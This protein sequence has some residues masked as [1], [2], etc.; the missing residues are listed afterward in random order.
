MHPRKCM[1]CEI[2]LNGDIVF[3][4]KLKGLYLDKYSGINEETRNEIPKN[5][6]RS[7]R[8]KYLGDIRREVNIKRYMM[9]RKRLSR[10]MAVNTEIHP[11]RHCS[12][13]RELGM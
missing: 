2:N 6:L 7:Q 9:P 10:T 5:L 8:Q 3:I 1:N 13:A 12:F 4:V 11:S